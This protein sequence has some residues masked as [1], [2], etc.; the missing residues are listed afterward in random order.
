M[1]AT[2]SL[3]LILCVIGVT[4][5]GFLGMQTMHKN[6]LGC[7]ANG[8]PCPVRDG[9]FAFALFHLQSLKGSIANAFAPV[10]L[11]A[12]VL[13]LVLVCVAA[14]FDRVF[15]SATRRKYARLIHTFTFPG[16][17]RREAWLALHEHS[18][19]FA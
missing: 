16:E 2:L 6:N 14:L 13:M 3:I 12:Y 15:A 9:M 10:P 1:K 19:S 5:F 11:L 18:P 4:I 7:F 8:M 17:V